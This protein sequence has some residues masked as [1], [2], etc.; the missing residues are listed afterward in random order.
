[1]RA[2]G[3]TLVCLLAACG[4]S[5]F[6]TRATNP[7]IVDYQTGE[8]TGTQ[9]FR[10]GIIST[11]A[12]RRSIFIDYNTRN[13]SNDGPK[14]CAEPPA[15]AIDS[16]ANAF[17]LI[18]S[19][20]GEGVAEAKAELSRNFA[21]SSGLGLYRSQGLQL[22]RDQ[23]FLLCIMLSQGMIDK[24]QWEDTYEKV[25]VAAVDLIKAEEPAM[26]EAAKRPALVVAAPQVSVTP[27]KTSN[28]PPPPSTPKS[29]TK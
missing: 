29:S 6:S 26:V 4:N 3:L 9:A 22:L 10:Y 8:W 20:K 11:T 15:D 14:V 13:G 27:S 2:F 12:G 28:E 17:S 1:M 23:T 5:P 21:V 25:R 16:F 24:T 18:G 19:G 7:V